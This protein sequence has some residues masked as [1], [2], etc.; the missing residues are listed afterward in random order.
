MH[1]IYLRKALP[2]DIQAVRCTM[3][4]S[5]GSIASWNDGVILS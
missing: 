4:G 5:Y 3:Y 1:Y 2:L